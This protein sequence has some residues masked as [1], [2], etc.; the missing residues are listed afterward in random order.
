[1][2]ELKTHEVPKTKARS[3]LGKAR[4]FLEVSTTSLGS[5]R[6]DAALL[7]AIHAGLSACDAV[8]VALRGVRSIEPDH[9]RAADLLEAAARE[10][11]DVQ[12][13]A[14]QLRGLLKVKNL[15]EYEDRRVSAREAETGS[16]RAE[17]LV[18]WAASV[19]D[20]AWI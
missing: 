1:V 12:Q 6:Y 20:R 19:V 4:Q 3:Y 8:T 5:E 16:K 13:H 7:L 11:E 14:S 17:R 9:L 10:A 18:N 15:V 2:A